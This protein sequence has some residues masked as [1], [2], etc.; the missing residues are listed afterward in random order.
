MDIEY[1][2]RAKTQELEREIAQIQL[3]S[4]AKRAKSHRRAAASPEQR[5]VSSMPL[6]L[7]RRACP[8]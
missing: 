5:T 1:I 3:A 4:A 6:S 2:S 7:L 8:S